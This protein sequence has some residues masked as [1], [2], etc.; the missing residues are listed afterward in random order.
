MIN[1]VSTGSFRH[2]LNP[3]IPVTLVYLVYLLWGPRGHALLQPGRRRVKGIQYH[4]AELSSSLG[5]HQTVSLTQDQPLESLAACRNT[6]LQL[7]LRAKNP[8]KHASHSQCSV[9]CMCTSEPLQPA[10]HARSSA[11][12]FH[13]LSTYSESRTGFFLLP[14]KDSSTSPH[15]CS[16]LYHSQRQ[17]RPDST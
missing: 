14:K 5:P 4:L 12:V 3:K 1:A 13:T 9:P 17:S 7:Y 16:L 8:G 10:S 2:C 11:E 6:K 15:F